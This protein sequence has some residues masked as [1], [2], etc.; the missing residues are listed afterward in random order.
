MEGETLKRVQQTVDE[1]LLVIDRQAK[2]CGRTVL[3]V[4]WQC[5]WGGP[6]PWVY[7]LG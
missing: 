5:A 4:L 2:A 7:S 3:P 1:I 6:S